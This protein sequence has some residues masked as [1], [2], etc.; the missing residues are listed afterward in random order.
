V[1]K[2]PASETAKANLNLVLTTR[3]FEN[4]ENAFGA[5][6]IKRGFARTPDDDLLFALGWPHVRYLSEGH[7]DD[8]LTDPVAIEKA[9]FKAH[10]GL[11]VPRGIALRRIRAFSSYAL[12]PDGKLRQGAVRAMLNGD[13]MSEEEAKTFVS[14]HL[15][16]RALGTRQLDIIFLLE[17]LAGPDAIAEAIT[18]SFENAADA[19]LLDHA[20]DKSTWAFGLGFLLLRAKASLSVA[21]RERLEAILRRCPKEDV[22]SHSVANVL[23]QVLHQAKASLRSDHTDQSLLLHWIDEPPTAIRAQLA[24][25]ARPFGGAVYARMVFLGGEDVIDYYK[26]HYDKVKDA[27]EQRAIV[28]QFG[29]IASPKIRELIEAMSDKSKAENDARAWLDENRSYR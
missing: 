23:D 6:Y 7:S 2:S 24:A 25:N 27:A 9:V 28:A 20:A 8:L 16:G 15:A 17:A 1:K 12:G 29:R 19:Q 26:K 14:E 4:G 22:N 21:L 11:E 10:V 3:A 13:P 5:Q 18:R